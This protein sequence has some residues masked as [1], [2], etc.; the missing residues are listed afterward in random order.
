MS[1][2]DKSSGLVY[3]ETISAPAGSMVQTWSTRVRGT[4]INPSLYRSHGNGCS[5]LQEMALRSCVWH[6]QM[7]EPEALQWLGWHYARQI[8]NKIK[9]SDALTFNI[10]NTFA[11]A[12][13]N[14]IDRNHQFYVYGYESW[15]PE[16]GHATARLP[17]VVDRL[18]KLDSSILTF[19]CIHGLSQRN[20]LM[21]LTKLDALAA[22][23]LEYS[24]DIDLDVMETS[25]TQLR[26]WG[27]A[28][29]EKGAFKRLK[30]LV[31]GN[32][33]LW[34]NAIMKQ[35]SSFPA[36]AL[37]GIRVWAGS[38][39]E[40]CEFPG[41]WSAISNAWLREK[42]FSDQEH[43]PYSMWADSNATTS[44]KLEKIYNISGKLLRTP[45]LDGPADLS[46]SV[47]YAGDRT[48]S[49]LDHVT[50]YFRDPE[51]ENL[52]LTKR[53]GENQG[54]DHRGSGDTNKKR[55]VRQNKKVEVGS[56]LGTFT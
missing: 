20:D 2:F 28:V 29:F 16:D 15:F 37:I 32:S 45:V 8:Y 13:P 49:P 40:A 36:L 38:E 35:V 48:C 19:L 25:K 14:E 10:W 33:G 44:S 23:L 51:K 53:I 42:G 11:K 6:V 43:N 12:F 30:V 41:D 55:K 50:W 3:T 4:R 21:I 24:Q 56:L 26:N 31:L 22:L 1:L 27:R 9:Q 18:A 34:G 54:Q 17:A 39:K 7:I 47:T 52:H 5:S 46:V